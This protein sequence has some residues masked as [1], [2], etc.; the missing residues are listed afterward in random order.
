MNDREYMAFAID[1]AEKGRGF[2][3]PNPL[4]GAVIVKEDRIIGYGYHQHCGGLHAERN[5][6]AAC[7][8]DPRGAAIYVTLEPCCHYGRTPPCTEA[9]IERGL[10]KVVIGSRD[11]NPLVCGKGVKILREAGIQVTT[12]FMKEECDA[13]NPV[14]FHYITHQTPY[15]VM[16]YAMTMDGKI[17]TA[18]G[19]SKWITGEKARENVHRDRHR[20]AAIMVGTGTVIKDDPLLTCRI[21]GG[22][23]PVRIICDTNLSIPVTAKVITTAGQIS[24][25]MATSCGDRD[26]Q[27]P[28]IDRG[29]RI[30]EIPRAADGRLSLPHLMKAL[31]KDGVDSIL[32]EGGGALNWSALEAGI[33]NKVQAY[34]APKIF[35]G[36]T[37]KTPVAGAGA[38]LPSHGFMLANQKITLMGD[39]ILIESEVVPCSQES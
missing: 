7:T 11:P 33:V 1:L 31:A 8:E 19:A 35:G 22:K 30:L 28:Y 24:T 32:L 39:D 13:L 38:A 27:Q 12:D 36:E 17:A 34:I 3:S 5:A 6:L 9:I 20:F 10:S 16:K 15:V 18:T 14:F 37:A 25:I 21:P 29:L 4:V 2:T 26:K 23:N